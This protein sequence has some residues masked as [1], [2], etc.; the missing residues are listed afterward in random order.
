MRFSIAEDAITVGESGPWRRIVIRTPDGHQTPVLTSL[1]GVPVY[2]NAGDVDNGCVG[3]YC[4][5]YQCV[6]LV[7]RYFALRWG[8]PDVW[9][10]VYGAADMRANH[11]G[12][13]QFIPNGGLPGPQQVAARLA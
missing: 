1:D 7:Q 8:Y 12:D 11:P 5:L 6:E 4:I 13:I 9:A 2:S 3:T 10:G